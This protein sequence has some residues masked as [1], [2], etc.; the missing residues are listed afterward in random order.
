MVFIAGQAN[1]QP[2]QHERLESKIGT[3][4]Q[5]ADRAT[6]ARGVCPASKWI[7]CHNSVNI[8]VD[9]DDDVDGDDDVNDDDDDDVDDDDGVD[10]DDDNT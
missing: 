2:C 3:P 8:D 9:D 1:A 6:K 10:Y 7:N 4:V 5:T